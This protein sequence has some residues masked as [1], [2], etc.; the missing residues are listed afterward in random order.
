MRPAEIDHRL[1]GEDHAG[2]ERDTFAR[3][4]VVQDVRHVVEQAADAMAAK[5]AHDA[6]A[7]ALGEIL[8]G[9]ADVAGGGARPDGGDAAHHGFVCHLDQPLG[10]A[11]DLADLDHAAGIAV[12]AVDDQRHVNVGDVAVAQRLVARNAVADDVV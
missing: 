8:D 10:G 4:A 11:L 3:A 1:D 5:I 6:A 2:L 7:L 9:K 12:P